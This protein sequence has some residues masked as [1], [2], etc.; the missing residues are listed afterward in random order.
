MEAVTRIRRAAF[1]LEY[2][3]KDITASLTP[4][5]NSITYTDHLEGESDELEVEVSNASGRWLDAWYPEKGAGLNLRLGWEGEPL[6]P[7]GQF[8]LDDVEFRGPPSIVTLRALAAPTG[9]PIR[10][11]RHENHAAGTLADVAAK[12]AG[13]HRF[14][15]VGL[16]AV[17]LRHEVLSQSNETDLA[18]LAR[19]ARAWGYLFSQRGTQLVFTPHADLDARP[20]VLTVHLAD[21]KEYSLR[22]KA[23][24]VYRACTLKYK[25]TK[26]G[27]DVEH[28]VT[29]P[30]ASDEGDTLELRD[31]RAESKAHA[32]AL[33][34]AA[35]RR[36][37]GRRTEGS[38]KLVGDPRLV[39]GNNL[40]LVGLGRLDGMYQIKQA[41][42]SYARGG[43]WE[44]SVEVSR[45]R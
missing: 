21:I 6:L 44:V 36:S 40:D 9:T 10:T 23:D 14:T 19:L 34:L 27:T 16:G 30:G 25:D 20:A 26:T 22:D 31:V 11:K 45:V 5:I 29:A 38:F 12:I 33:G 7:C 39:S 24:G 32:E 8:T 41:R 28:T 4:I 13:R 3:N 37:Q 17:T 18:F 1:L 43:G 15:V 42:H 35:I 2:D